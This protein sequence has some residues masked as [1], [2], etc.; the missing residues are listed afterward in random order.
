[1]S[2]SSPSTKPLREAPTDLAAITAQLTTI[3]LPHFTSDDA[4]TIGTSLRARIR[5]LF[6]GSA[7]VINITAANSDTLLFHCTTSPGVNPDNDTW[8]SR[9]RAT[10]KRWG[11]SSWYMHHKMGGREDEFQRKYM[12]GDRA[13]QYAIHGGGVPVRVEGVE[14]VVGVIVVS[15]LKQHEDHQVV[16]EALEEFI[17]GHRGS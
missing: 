15:G 7:T 16:I 14:G 13:G 12:L 1:M 8:V 4:W 9:K 11:V 3:T 17:E 5:T 10:V 6:P 2:S